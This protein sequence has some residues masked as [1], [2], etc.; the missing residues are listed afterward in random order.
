VNGELKKAYNEWLGEISRRKLS[1]R[2]E[3]FKNT[4]DVIINRLYTPLDTQ[5]TDY[6]DGIGFPGQYPFTRGIQP[7]MYRGQIWTMRQYSGFGTAEESNRRYKYLLEQGQTGLSVAFDLPTQ[8]GLD[9]DHEM[10]EGEVGRVGVAID[11]LEDMEILFD[12]IALDQVSTSMTINAPASIL[13]AMYAAVAEKQGIPLAKLQGT[14]QNDILKEYVARGT[15]IF[16]PEP[17]MKL[18]VDTIDYCIKNIPKWNFISVG[19]YHIREAGSTAAQEVAFAFSNAIAYVERAISAGLDVD[20][21][22]PRISWIFNTHNNFFEEIAKYRAARRLWARIMKERFGA[23]NERSCMFRIHIQ[24]GGSTLTAQ[25]PLNNIIRSTAHCMAS[26]LGGTQSLAIS[27]Y[28]EACAIPTEESACMSLRIQQV[29]AYETGITDTVDP[30]AGSYYIESLTNQMEKKI[31]EYIT[32][33]DQMG[34]AIRAIESGYMQ[35]QINDSSYR[36]YS[37][38]ESGR[39]VLVGVNMFQIEGEEPLKEILRV[40]PAI[41]DLQIKKLQ[42]IK[43]RR[44]NELAGSALGQLKKAASTSENLMPHIVNAVKSYAT[45]GEICD[46]LRSVFGSYKGSI[47]Y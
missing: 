19:G 7:T 38:I 31:E 26:V 10:A 12:G 37:E 33:V 24:D 4:S 9:S 25:Q 43:Q 40:D 14:I 32:A 17:S 23:R 45:L 18:T 21:F 13:L 35:R 8:I 6:L 42:G 20:S 15:Y 36:Y 2:Q 27:S 44:D 3:Q 1:E 22:A 29:V 5:D 11:S 46:T 39:R 16:P 41:R 28:D 47:E 34:G 30:L